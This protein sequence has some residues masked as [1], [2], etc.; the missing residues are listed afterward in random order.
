MATEFLI[1]EIS[2]LLKEGPLSKTSDSHGLNT[3]VACVVG[4]VCVVAFGLVSAARVANSGR[5]RVLQDLAATLRN[6]LMHIVTR[7]E[8]PT[9][10]ADGILGSLEGL[11]HNPGSSSTEASMLYKGAV[12][13][14][15]GFTDEFWAGIRVADDE[16]NAK[17][18]LMEVDEDF[19]S[20]GS[21]RSRGDSPTKE[22]EHDWLRASTNAAA[23]RAC[24]I[25]KVCEISV[26]GSQPLGE[27]SRGS[28]LSVKYIEYLT[29]LPPQE[30]LSCRQFFKTLLQSGVDLDDSGC[31]MLLEY[32]GQAVLQPYELER[33]E[34]AMA[35]CLDILT[36]LADLWTDNER[37]SIADLGAS[38]YDWFIKVM[39]RGICSPHVYQCLALMLQRV[40]KVQPEYAKGLGLPSARTSLFR[41]LE[42][43]TIAV[44]F[45]VG[46]NISDIFG[47]FIL[48]EHDAILDDI[49]NSLP[50]VRD[51]TEGIALRLFVL[52]HLGSSWSTLLR[53]CTYAIFETAGQVPNSA[54]HAKHCVDYMSNN[55][56]LLDSQ[57]LFKLF[58]SQIIFTWL[59]SQSILTIPFSIFG[60]SSL[61]SLLNDV[62]DEVTGQVVMRGRIGEAQQ[63]V[64]TLSLPYD[65]L[66]ESSFSKCAA[67]CI[68]RDATVPPARDIQASGADARLR[69]LLGKERYGALI[70]NHFQEILAIL[71]KTTD[72]DDNITK[73]F[74]KHEGY[75][76]AYEAYDEI[77]SCGSST[78]VLPASQQP[79][80]KAG[81]LIDEIE[82]LHSRTTYNPEAV[83]SPALYVFIL[84]ELLNSIHAALGSLHTCSVIRRIRILVCM[85]GETAL[86]G[87]PLEMALHSVRPFLTDTYCADDAMGIVQY[88][89]NHGFPYLQEAPS[90]L[91]GLIVSILA[92]MKKFLNSPQESTTQESQFRETMSKAQ[93]FQAW[94]SAFA[95]NYASPH[96]DDSAEHSFR[97]VVLSARH[98]RDIGNARKGTYESDLLLELLKNR[99]YGS[100]LIDEASQN[101]ILDLLCGKFE[102][103]ASFRDDIIGSEKQA[104]AYVSAVW[105]TCQNRTHAPDYLLWVARVLGR[106]YGGT[107]IVELNMSREVQ[108]I[109]NFVDETSPQQVLESNSRRIILHQL[110]NVVLADSRQ[111]ASLAERTLQRIVTMAKNTE[112]MADCE[113]VLPATSMAAL[114]WAPFP[115]PG[116]GPS[117]I[118]VPSLQEAVVLNDD[119]PYHTW[120]RQLCIALVDMCPRDKVLSELKP[121]LSVVDGLPEKLFPSILHLVLLAETDKQQT[122][123]QIMSTAVENIF[124]A[125]SDLRYS[126]TKILLKS[127]IYL[128][129]QPLLHENT[130]ADR[131]HWLEFDYEH[132]ATAAANCRMYK[133]ALLLLEIGFSE[134]SKTKRS[135]RSSGLKLV[136]PTELL[137]RIFRNLENKDSF[138]GIRQPSSLSTMMDQLEYEK[139]GFKSLSFRGANFDAQLRHLQ[140]PVPSAE[141]DLIKVLDTLDLN[142]LSQSVLSN[143]T[144]ASIMSTKAMLRTARKLERWDISSPVSETNEASTIFRV[145]QDIHRASDKKTIITALDRGFRTTIGS[146]LATKTADSSLHSM[147]GCLA[148]LAEI[149]DIFASEGSEQFQEAWERI[150][151]RNEW[152][153]AER[154][155]SVYIALGIR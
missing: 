98:L 44:K 52:A 67:Y 85:A 147:L 64:E 128:R 79:S 10:A 114:A 1:V 50:T 53:R 37:E 38:L 62:Q 40:I 123:K 23:H 121:T 66:L 21:I 102:V 110:W 93:S 140:K 28:I 131:C 59:E 113:R 108:V 127:I 154:Y 11:L 77:T 96:L 22:L 124:K 125:S 129:G 31:I 109:G 74:Q 111:D 153:F 46:M 35:A 4:S 95:D 33:C 45:E 94:L 155:T 86:R 139:A 81:Y 134:T 87:Y 12:E 101:Q 7:Q 15:L 118:Q 112:I 69:K 83:W 142:G 39:A 26:G 61:A 92:S 130:T 2:A 90:F 73:G 138:Y 47:L 149:E 16:A 65:T 30:F 119:M 3:E 20:Q 145:F 60:Y 89:L 18:D 24:L 97:A 80:F 151:A 34:V 141:E 57:E 63:L 25:A 49:V 136:V 84:R 8:N 148:V 152:M 117:N 146:L 120:V 76:K 6:R 137:L 75:T 150:E 135:R 42:E 91:A 132:A 54:K 19:E 70:S 103:G 143:M 17:R 104:A 36:G 133:T 51:W 14:A 126:H 29:S 55:L 58:V 56:Q 106:A 82:Y 5:T 78:A 107:G 115:C 41:I 32:L 88:L 144:S 100:K 68:A 99:R 27:N 71:Y 43:G 72:R 105:S 9:A 122:T 13:T 48:K 116:I